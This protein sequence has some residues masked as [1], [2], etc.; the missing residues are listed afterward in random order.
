M[1]CKAAQGLHGLTRGGPSLLICAE[2]RFSVSIQL[3]SGQ[4]TCIQYNCVLQQFL[5]EL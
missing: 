4:T 3:K 2:N 5:A 1:S